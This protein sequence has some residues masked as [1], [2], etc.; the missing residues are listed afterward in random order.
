MPPHE[1]AERLA[2]C[3]LRD[4]ARVEYYRQRAD[5]IREAKGRKAADKVR[6]TNAGLERRLERAERLAHELACLLDGL[7][8]DILGRA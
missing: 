5:R 1:C 2:A 3:L 7:R 4:A 8:N 6:R